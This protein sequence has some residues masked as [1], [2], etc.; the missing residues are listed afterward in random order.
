MQV[1]S[2]ESNEWRPPLTEIHV[3]LRSFL[4]VFGDF[5]VK[6]NKKIVTNNREGQLKLNSSHYFSG[7]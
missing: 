4:A 7:G 2:K 6:R 1:N 5:S 3:I